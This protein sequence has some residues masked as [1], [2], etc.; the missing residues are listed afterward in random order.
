MAIERT[1]CVVVCCNLKT[2]LAIID[3]DRQCQIQKCWN[4]AGLA[5]P[6]PSIGSSDARQPTRQGSRGLT[7]EI[8]STGWEFG[9]AESRSMLLTTDRNS[10]IITSVVR[11]KLIRGC[12]SVVERNLAKVDVARSN[13]VSRLLTR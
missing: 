4:D 1:Y 10:V 3:R 13:R 12:S 5:C 8:N 7:A 2:L 11:K 6:H 9:I